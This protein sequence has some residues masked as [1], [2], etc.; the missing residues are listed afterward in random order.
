MIKIEA[1]KNYIVPFC[2]NKRILPYGDLIIS[3][4][5]SRKTVKIK[6]EGEKQYI[7]FNRKKYYVR[8]AGSLYSPKFVIVGSIEDV[9]ER[10]TEA[11]YKYEIQSE[12][13]LRVYFKDKT[14]EYTQIS[15]CDDKREDF[16]MISGKVQSLN[17]W[18]DYKIENWRNLL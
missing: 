2:G 11:G 1:L 18:I 12:K 9:A 14:G 17:E 15:I 16:Y 4:G 8:N 6:D 13:A 10:L 5:E 3:D 7:T